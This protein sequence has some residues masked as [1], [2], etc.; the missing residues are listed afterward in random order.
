MES[1]IPSGAGAWSGQLW[2]WA[3]A[4]LVWTRGL[5]G[6]YGVPRRLIRS[7]ALAPEA[8]DL[9]LDMA[10]YRLGRGRRLPLDL[11]PFRWPVLGA[12]LAYAIVK[13]AL[14]QFEALVIL[15]MLGPIAAMDLALEPR[16]LSALGAARPEAASAVEP[17]SEALR[18][19]AAATLLSI[20]ATLA[21]LAIA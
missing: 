8:A 17:L 5:T 6:A 11:S 18:M 7:A 2:F 3:A 20:V 1:E 4:I 16:I 15:A 21:S 9:A 12:A 19:R 14:G 13:A 10:R